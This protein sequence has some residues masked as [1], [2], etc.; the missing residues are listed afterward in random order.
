MRARRGSTGSA[1]PTCRRLPCASAIVAV[2]AFDDDWVR[3][4]LGLPAAEQPLYLL[5]VGRI[6]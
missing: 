2:G 3:R 4:V 6:R 1:T 5:P